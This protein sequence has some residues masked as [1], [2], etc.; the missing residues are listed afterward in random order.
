MVEVKLEGGL[1]ASEEQM[2]AALNEAGMVATA[3]ALK[4]FDTESTPL[5]MGG[6][7]W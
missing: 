2:L 3:Q 4:R 7:R 5:D 1:L 6:S